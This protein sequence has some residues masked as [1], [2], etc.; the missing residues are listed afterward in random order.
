MRKTAHVQDRSLKRG[1]T[2]TGPAMGPLVVPAH[3]CKAAPSA[4]P[5][6]AMVYARRLL[7]YSFSLSRTHLIVSDKLNQVVYNSILGSQ[8]TKMDGSRYIQVQVFA[9]VPCHPALQSRLQMHA[10]IDVNAPCAD[11]PAT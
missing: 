6:P 9:L 3:L 7:Q 8:R 11:V 2:V 10:V 4:A 1:H 5:A